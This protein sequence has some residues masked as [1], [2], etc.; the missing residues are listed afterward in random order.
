MPKDPSQIHHRNREARL[1]KRSK[2]KDN[3]GE[4]HK[5]Y[6]E[7]NA[8]KR[9]E[10]MNET[11]Q[12]N[13]TR[14]QAD[15]EE[16]KGLTLAN[17]ALSMSKEE[18]TLANNALSKSKEELTMEN[19]ALSKSKEELMMTNNALSES[20]EELTMANNTL[21]ES[22]EELTMANNTL[23]QAD[24]R[25]RV[26]V[27]GMESDIDKMELVQKQMTKKLGEITSTLEAIRATNI[28]TNK[29]SN[30]RELSR[31]SLSKLLEKATKDASTFE[32]SIAANQDE[33]SSMHEERMNEKNK[34]IQSG[35]REVRQI[36]RN[37][38]R[39]V[40]PNRLK[41]S[42]KYIHDKLTD[43][44]MHT[45]NAE[46]RQDPHRKKTRGASGNQQRAS[47]QEQ[48]AQV[49]TQRTRD[50]A[51]QNVEIIHRKKTLHRPP[52]HRTPNVIRSR[53]Y[54]CYI[55]QR[56]RL[57]RDR[58]KDSRMLRRFVLSVYSFGKYCSWFGFLCVDNNQTQV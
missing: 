24:N 14:I 4:E 53:H 38:E 11:L 56:P 15:A 41:Y 33:A 47:V 57:R 5:T 30:A 16:I 35:R 9:I 42:N 44:Q 8:T 37:F 34:Q 29:M 23:K 28:A 31:I 49:H 45:S 22:K 39:L 18:L 52:N 26:M 48:P 6:K 13:T 51:P 19:N 58:R 55:R 3:Y 32:E 25:L 46:H 1:V 40:R 54:Q 10:K 20:N 12:A 2:N 17:N 36:K 50:Q 43:T 27:N 21:S 7:F